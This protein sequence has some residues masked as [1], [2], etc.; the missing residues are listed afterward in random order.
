MELTT[1]AAW[2]SVHPDTDVL[3]IETGHNRNYRSNPYAGYFRQSELMFPVH[4]VSD[5]LPKKERILGIW[6]ESSALAVPVSAFGKKSGE[7]ERPSAQLRRLFAI[8]SVDVS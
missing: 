4:P 5:V 7:V 1:W 3:S 8:D 6:D 2:Q